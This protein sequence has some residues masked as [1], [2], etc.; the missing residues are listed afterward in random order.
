MSR[1]LNRVT[2]IGNLGRDPELK[3]TPNGVAVAE[4]S[5]ATTE[6]VKDEDKTEWHNLVFWDKLAE[7]AGKYLAKGSKV[8]VAG[9]LQT[10][11]WD[12]KDGAKKYKTEV[13]VRELIMLDGK[14]SV[15]SEV[16][17]ETFEPDQISDDDIPF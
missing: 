6:R 16:G 14:G 17:S 13:V 15:K 8:Y 11:S 4:M 9:R 2:L 12:G 10:R 1:S 7:V 5:I 3:Y